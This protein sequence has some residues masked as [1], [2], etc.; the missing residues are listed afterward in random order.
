MDLKDIKVC[1]IC[2]RN[3]FGW[4]NNAQPVNDGRCCDDCNTMIV[5]PERISLILKGIYGGGNE[6]TPRDGS[7]S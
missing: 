6:E 5:L 3:Y 4:G 2:Q 1:S 7:S